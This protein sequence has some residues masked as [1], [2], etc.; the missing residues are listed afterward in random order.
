MNT[1]KSRP[2]REG[3]QADSLRRRQRV[4]AALGR[5]A[6]EGTEIS[7]AGIAPRRRS[8]QDVHLPAPRPA[9]ENPR[10]PG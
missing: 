6:A 7:A 5:A 3:R 10:P 4:T 1:A 8:R 2:M 9:G